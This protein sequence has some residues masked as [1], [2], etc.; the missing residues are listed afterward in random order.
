MDL[1]IGLIIGI[2]SG[3]GIAY[4]LLSSAHGKTKQQL[5]R[6]EA[7]YE[8]EL[9]AADE[10]LKLLEEARDNLKDSFKALSAD[11]LSKNNESFIKLAEENLKKYQ[12]SAKDDLEKRQ[13][14]I[15]KTVEPVSQTLK[16]FSERVNKIEERRIESEGGIKKELEKL[17]EM[18]LR[19][20]QST[21]SLVKALRAPQVRGQ[22]G[23]MHLRRT[24][25]MAGMI[26][27]CDFEEQS[28]VETD[29]GQRQR[30]DMLIR[31]PN[32][33]RVVVDSKVPIAAYLDALETDSPES[34]S[35]R[36]QAHARHL[37]THIK[38][39]ST[40]AYWSQFDNAPEFVVLFIPN[41][42]IFS[43]A[44]EED[45]SLIELGVEN[46]VILA[47]PTTLIALLKAVAYGWQQEAITREA[48][49][50]A[51][52]GREIYDRLSVVIGHFVKLG[53]SIDQSVGNYNKAMNSVDSRLMV[54]AR[55]FESLESAS[56][57]TLPEINQ[58]EKRPNLPTSEID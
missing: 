48:K 38:D 49:E 26:N 28:S 21:S 57:E 29:E 40:K 52:L 46:K 11:A 50:I 45:P 56:T 7:K 32:E 15:S 22:W 2:L 54:T 33:R 51:A 44:L 25:E 12:Q 5:A 19:L 34:Q 58:I 47:T 36:M 9:K 18:H 13:Q 24:V 10:K 30:P 42:A 16:T 27:Y 20:D 8:A 35:E 17:S 55:K 53:K 1:F 39:L 4:F 14:A 37:R 23:E 41:E 43:A 31:L 6:V 3:F